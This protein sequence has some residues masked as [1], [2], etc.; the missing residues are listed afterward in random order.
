[1]DSNDLINIANQVNISNFLGVFADDQIR[2][3]KSNQIGTMIVNTDPSYLPGGHW[4]SLFL[5]DKDIFVYDPLSPYINK[6]DNLK[7]FLIRMNKTLHFNTIQ[8]QRVD[9]VM[10]GYHALVF[11]FVMKNGG[12]EKKFKSFLQ[13]F[14]SYNVIDREQLSLT[15]YTII[16]K[17]VI[18]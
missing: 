3:I 5:S 12:N 6:S 1:M 13:T 18:K 4:L 11:C 17:N 9:S 14:A 2:C 16:R 8:I 15:Y 7:K 10:C